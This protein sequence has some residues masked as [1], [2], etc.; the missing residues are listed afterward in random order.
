MAAKMKAVDA[1]VFEV[2]HCLEIL[3]SSIITGV[4]HDPLW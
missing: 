4:G 1:V 3:A 2:V